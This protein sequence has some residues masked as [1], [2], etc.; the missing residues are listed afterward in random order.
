MFQKKMAY[1]S[2]GF[3][4]SS[5]ICDREVNYDKGICPVAE[6]L[7]DNT[8]LGLDMCLYELSDEDVDLIIKAFVKV[9]KNI[10]LL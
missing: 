3:P 10:N 6:N 2:R 8:F 7:H 5:D 9:W 1:G 4:W